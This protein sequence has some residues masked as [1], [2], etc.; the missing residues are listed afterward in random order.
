MKRL[1]LIASLSILA[2][3]PT[4]FGGDNVPKGEWVIV[5]GGP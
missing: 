3:A 5:V 2:L 1:L 4:A